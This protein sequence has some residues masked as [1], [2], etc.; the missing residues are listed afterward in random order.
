MNT[1][2]IQKNIESLGFTVD[3]TYD[4]NWDTHTVVAHF[5]GNEW[6]TV[7]RHSLQQAMIESLYLVKSGVYGSML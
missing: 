4:S 3:V 2:T 6:A 5:H 7:E 1:H